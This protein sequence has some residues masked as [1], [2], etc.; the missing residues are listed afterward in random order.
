MDNDI[1]LA[2]RPPETEPSP[3]DNK[4]P[5]PDKTEVFKTPEEIAAG[6]AL[7]DASEAT[8]QTAVPKDT[9]RTASSGGWKEKLTLHWPPSK[10]E[11]IT[12]GVILLL[13]VAGGLGWAL[14]H[15]SKPATIKPIPKVTA[16]TKTVPSTLTGLPVDPSVNKRTVTGVMIENT[17]FARPQSGLGQAG[18]VFE[19]VAEAGITRFL[20]LYQDTAPD[21]IGPIRSAR[22]YYIQWLLGF[23]AGYAHVGGS[24]DALADI[25]AWGVH[26]LDQ[27]AN[28]GS[29]HRI[30]SR[31]AP[32]NV[33]TS[34]S[35]L[36]QLEVNKGYI[37][38][39]YTGFAHKKKAFRK[40]TQPIT[41]KSINMA[42]SGPTY[43]AHYDYDVKTDS[44]LRS[45]GGAP[46][47]DANTNQ[48]ISPMVVIALVTPEGQGA[49]DSSG[50]YYSN[51]NVI[52]SG[53]AYIFQDGTVT[54]GQWNKA[55]NTSQ[56]KFTDAAGKT[57]LLNPGQAWLTAV[58]DSSKVSYTP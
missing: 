32:H 16:Q 40:K 41:A 1:R 15:K 27:F 5:K 29:Y 26:D 21:N 11:W 14:T 24:P 3:A 54:A 46:Q 47:I 34:I 9:A 52:G 23:D 20:A 57:I 58:S 10:K 43:D 12:F 55:S 42:L 8:Q 2:K 17:T 50:A 49:L 38:S 33:Y 19:A 22:P 39:H 25:K 56:L 44:Y 18:V 51:Y 13:L 6:Q 35:T 48:Q 30:G 45:E 28:S 37:T 36:N 4:Q 53:T 31:V 7:R